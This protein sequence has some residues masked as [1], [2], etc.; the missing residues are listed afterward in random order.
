MLEDHN[1][2]ISNRN[3]LRR[4]VIVGVGVDI[5]DV[6]RFNSWI[7]WEKGKLARF[8][9]SEELGYIFEP[10]NIDRRME[11]MAI[12]FAMKEA[13]L[14][15]FTQFLL[16][17]ENKNFQRRPALFFFTKS[18]F[19]SQ[20]KLGVPVAKVN[21]PQIEGFFGISCSDIKVQ[22]SVSHSKSYGVVF[23]ILYKSHS[24]F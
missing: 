5:V 15:A 22:F 12:C 4:K 6:S 2:N 1:K 9:G 20:T 8:F 3:L 21:W 14:K 18:V 24:F 11:R 13:F 23:L 17:D 19:L 10:R 7:S 16:L